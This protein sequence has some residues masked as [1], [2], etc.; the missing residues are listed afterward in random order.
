MFLDYLLLPV[1]F[2]IG[3][4]TSY[5]DIR[6]GKIKN[7]WIINGLVWGLGVYIALYI[8]I[9]LSGHS[10]I[11]PKA[12]DYIA[13]AYLNQALL[14]A[15]ISLALGYAGWYFD[16]LSAGDAKLFFIFSLL[17]PLTFYSNTYWVL[18]PSFA[19]LLNIFIPVML[20]L[21]LHS[22]FMVISDFSKKSIL[23]SNPGPSLQKLK[24]Y[25]AD[26]YMAYLK[27]L[28]T[29]PLVIF[30]TQIIHQMLT[31]SAI[32]Y[33]WWYS[34]IVL[35][36]FVASRLV[37]QILKV[38]FILILALAAFAVFLATNNLSVT[39]SILL[40]IKG[41]FIFFIIFPIAT[42]VFS[43]SEQSDRQQSIPFAFWIFLGAI[44][45][46]LARGSLIPIIANFPAYFR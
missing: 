20:Y 22:L 37:R 30:S 36:P 44:I 31:G 11:I 19:L 42:F 14:N 9:L 24:T 12:G 1:L 25:L 46:V 38:N 45:T 33:Q 3:I 2:L 32:Q 27:I 15:L 5:Q 28:I 13:Y 23:L 29:I 18:Y 16:M 4:A 6:Y 7:N 17:L 8:W 39:L 21:L 41:S 43:Y 10:D 35:L 26:N 40:M 34:A